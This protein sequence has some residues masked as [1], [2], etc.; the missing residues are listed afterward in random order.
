M[1]E[2][3]GTIYAVRTE[4]SAE[5]IGGMDFVGKRIYNKARLPLNKLYWEDV[6]T[7]DTNCFCGAERSI[8]F[9]PKSHPRDPFTIDILS[10]SL[11]SVSIHRCRIEGQSISYPE[12]FYVQGRNPKLRALVH[13]LLNEAKTADD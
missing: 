4:I 10:S 11:R 6:W 8:L 13:T 3:G 9:V 12:L 5:S 7:G 2:Q 1:S